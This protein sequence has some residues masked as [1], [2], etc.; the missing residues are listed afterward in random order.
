MNDGLDPKVVPLRPANDR[1]KLPPKLEEIR[2]LLG[3]STPAGA[4]PTDEEAIRDPAAFRRRF[5]P[6]FDWSRRH[7]ESLIL[8]MHD[9]G[10]TDNEVKLFRHTGNLHRTAFS[11][12]LSVNPWVTL[13]GGSNFAFFTFVLGLLLIVLWPQISTLSVQALK[14]WGLLAGLGL[15]CAGLYVAFILPW[16]IERRTE[17]EA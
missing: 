4:V 15:L 12:R 14:G 11:V 10:L 8:L 7:R 17:K 5:G 1:K 9:K 6:G 3:E 2:K 16:L 13:W